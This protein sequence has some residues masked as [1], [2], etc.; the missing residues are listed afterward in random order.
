MFGGLN[1]C[2]ISEYLKTL[3]RFYKKKLKHLHEKKYSF[4]LDLHKWRALTS[5]KKHCNYWVL[6]WDAVE[7]T[8]RYT[9]EDVN[10]AAE[11]VLIC[12][13]H[14]KTDRASVGTVKLLPIND[15]VNICAKRYYELYSQWYH[16]LQVDFSVSFEFEVY[17]CA[18]WNPLI[19]AIPSAIA[20]FLGLD[21]PNLYTGHAFRVTSAT[22]LA[23][24]GANTLVL[25]RHGR[26]KSDA[27][28]EG[29]VRESEGAIRDSENSF[30]K[31]NNVTV[32]CYK[33][34]STWGSSQY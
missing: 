23:D 15:D 9:W 34:R 13:R 19:S 11:G 24:E 32:S 29:Y 26:W 31:Q 25:K 18:S 17:Q 14:S 3:S 30:I 7:R 12:I 27:V 1:S 22:V 6:W 8:C 5:S 33:S 21:N 10:F 20:T 4:T 2:R 16:H 28:A